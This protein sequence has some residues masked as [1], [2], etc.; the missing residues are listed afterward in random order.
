MS[1]FALLVEARAEREASDPQGWMRVHRSKHDSTAI[2]AS[3]SLLRGLYD[4]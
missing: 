3:R 1:M 4:L 2:T